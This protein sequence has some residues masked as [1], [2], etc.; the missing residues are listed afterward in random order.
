M[1]IGYVPE[2]CALNRTSEYIKADIS[3]F[4]LGLRTLEQKSVSRWWRNPYG[5][6]F[7]FLAFTVDWVCDVGNFE[8]PPSIGEC[9]D[10]IFSLLILH[11]E[12][13]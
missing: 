1:Q 9:V 4:D 3:A 12:I 7:F 13:T 11:N 8:E 10:V 2:K 6:V 5:S